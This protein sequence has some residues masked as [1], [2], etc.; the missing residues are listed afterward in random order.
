[1]STS[2]AKALR[3]AGGAIPANRRIWEWLKEHGDHTGAE[4]SAA[5]NIPL[6][7]SSSIISQMKSRKMIKVS[8]KHSEHLGRK[9]GYYTTIGRNFEVLP[10]PKKNFDVA[11]STNIGLGK[12]AV[13]SSPASAHINTDD[14]LE[15][16]PVAKAFAL[17]QKLE[18]MFRKV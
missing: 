17:Y 1:M 2:I 18:G 15:T 9:V 6:A 3:K 14:I 16:M 13:S 4:V 7:A 5:L 12:M 8:D 11:A 10:L